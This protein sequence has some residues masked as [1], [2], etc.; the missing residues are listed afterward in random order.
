MMRYS[1]LYNEK[2]DTYRQADS[3]HPCHDH[4]AVAVQTREVKNRET[5]G[6]PLAARHPQAD[7]EWGGS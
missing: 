1:R 6:F 4:D 2:V 5:L 7:E 3:H